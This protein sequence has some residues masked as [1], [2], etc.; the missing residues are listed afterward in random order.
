MNVPALS[1][2]LNCFGLILGLG[3]LRLHLSLAVMV[4]AR[5]S[6]LRMSL[7]PGQRIAASIAPAAGIP[8]PGITPEVSFPIS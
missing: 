2:A 6:G 5:V 8:S 7:A 4:G 3:C 1:E